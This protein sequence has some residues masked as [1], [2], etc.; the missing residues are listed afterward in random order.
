MNMRRDQNVYFNSLRSI[1]INQ[2][3]TKRETFFHENPSL[4]YR[5]N[6]YSELSVVCI[7]LTECGGS[8]SGVC[9]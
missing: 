2:S 6:I 5:K 9:E 7:E 8:V 1:Q 4:I 3:F